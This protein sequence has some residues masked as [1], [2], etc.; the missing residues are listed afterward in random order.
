MAML[1]IADYIKCFRPFIDL[2]SS[3]QMP[4][5]FKEV[6]DCISE[7]KMPSPLGLKIRSRSACAFMGSASLD[8]L[9][10]AVMAKCS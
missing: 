8:F 4:L 6:M 10:K 2:A 1:T 3:D 7:P 5:R 9:A